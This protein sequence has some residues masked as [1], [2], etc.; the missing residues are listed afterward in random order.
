ME[1]TLEAMLYTDKGIAWRTT[2]WD[3]F[4][5]QR[6]RI[7]SGVGQGEKDRELEWGWGD[8]REED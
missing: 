4:C 3:E 7:R 8:L 2:I 5:E 1:E 6:I